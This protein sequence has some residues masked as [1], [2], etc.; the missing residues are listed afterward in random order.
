[1]TPEATKHNCGDP[2]LD[3]K[4]DLRVC[5]LH[6]KTTGLSLFLLRRVSTRLLLIIAGVATTWAVCGADAS[7]KANTPAQP[8]KD[9]QA[10][11]TTNQAPTTRAFVKDWKVDELVPPVNN[12]LKGK[13]NF[14]RGKK[15]FGEVSCGMCHHFGPDGGGVGP[16]LTGVSGSFSV[17]DLLEAIIEP[18]KQISSLYGTTVVRKK[19]G[20]TVTGWIPEETETTVSVM[21]DMF[22]ESKL[23]IVKRQDIERMEPSQVS[24]MPGGLLNTLKEEEILDLVAFLLSG[25]D[26]TLKMFR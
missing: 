5:S 16:D 26:S 11:G 24:L 6:H 21:E 1:M 4:T 25:G 12:G 23:T 3:L 10:T 8:L 14:E 20:D 9:Q 15:A 2:F 18:S 19:D 13:R 17:R 7:L 22:A